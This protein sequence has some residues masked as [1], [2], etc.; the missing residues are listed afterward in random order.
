MKILYA[1]D[2]PLDADQA[3]RAL[4]KYAPEI[5]LD[6]VC[7]Y[8]EAVDRLEKVSDYDLLLTD[9][10]LPDGDGIS[11]LAH[12]RE[13]DLPCAVVVISGKGDEETA[14]AALK[15]GADDYL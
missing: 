5:A 11:L 9:L 6:V 1:E 12:V 7:T 2:D 10:K 14:V 15:S 8:Q 13:L 3:L 4:K